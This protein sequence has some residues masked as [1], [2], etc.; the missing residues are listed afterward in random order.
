[1]EPETTHSPPPKKNSKRKRAL[2]IV[3]CIVIVLG[4]IL[5]AWWLLSGQFHE[6]TEDAYV[7]GNII[8]ITPQLDGTV[9]AVN[10]DDTDFV[11]AGEV[12]VRLDEADADIALADA[13]SKLARAVRNVR[14]LKATSEELTAT[15]ELRRADL[16]RADE[17]LARREKIKGSGAVSGEDVQHARDAQKVAQANLT[18]AMQQLEAT[19]ALV[20]NTTIRNHP[21]VLNAAAQVRNAY[22]TQARTRIPA[23]AAGFVAKRSVQVGQRV[24]A[25]STLMSVVPLNEVWV[26]ANFKESQ[27]AH[28]R[29]GQPVKLEAD[30]YGGRVEY[31][32]T[33][34][35]F[36]A[37][38][39]SAFA[40]LPAQN[41]TGNWIKVVQRLPVRIALDPKQLAAHPLQIGL[42]MSVAVDTSLR[43]GKRLT[44]TPASRNYAT[45]V[46][47]SV[48]ALADKRVD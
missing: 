35:G 27:L 2:L 46:F 29:I 9:I 16:A 17:D 8:Q 24:T 30:L 42:S 41:A 28:I 44:E 1:M 7:N 31:D 15:V 6:T 22:L 20:D 38:T 5:A 45:D 39:G 14:N 26:D 32:G 34:A 48:S 23:P 12:L 37:G 40:L 13:E 3:L 33:I 10:A 18:A 21:D 25:G 19:R 11:Q 36:S 43:D 47:K 4:A